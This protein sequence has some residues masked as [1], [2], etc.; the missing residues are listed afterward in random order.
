MLDGGI[1]GYSSDSEADKYFDM[2]L[3]GVKDEKN[4][5]R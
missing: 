1:Y 4:D 3:L 2:E 5:S